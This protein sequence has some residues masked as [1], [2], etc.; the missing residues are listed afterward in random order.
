MISEVRIAGYR[1]IRSLG[2]DLS[3]LTVVLGANGT[4][5]TNFYRA[6][7]LIHAAATGRLAEEIAAEGGMPSALWAGA[8][9]R[10]GSERDTAARG[11]GKGP[12][13]IGLG[14]SIED[15]AFRGRYEL[16]IGLPNLIS[17]PALPLDPVVR[18]ETV[19]AR[20]GGRDM[21]VMARK[22]PGLSLRG[23]DGRMETTTADL[24]MAETALG[25]SADALA[26]PEVQ[27]LQRMIAGW[28]FYH[29]FRTDPA[30]PLRQPAV[31]VTSPSLASDGRNWAAVLA[32][33]LEIE[34]G[35]DAARSD[36]ARAIGAAFPGARLGFRAEGA[37]LE[38]ELAMPEFPRP[39]T[40]AEL[41]D[42]TLRYL[43]LVAALA[44]LRPAPFIALNEPE[45]S[46]HA[47]LLGPL[48]AL[49]GQAASRSQI[50]VVT[51]APELA[52]RLELDHGARVLR[53]EKARGETRVVE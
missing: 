46:L 36:I 9:W 3:P 18:E 4:G 44:P 11:R 16:S 2:A 47:S 27:R 20:L 42:G 1:S 25:G 28:R 40:A 49:V 7:E 6:I 21:A 23:D 10:D 13:R 33:R 8:G 48:A 30:S 19:R 43:C 50:L 52:D 31:A 51:H 14:V 53:L 17:E 41:S 32:T 37:R 26:Q 39:F 22:G 34:D 24:L 38:P 29:A 45:T 15:E 12:V 5:K 35:R